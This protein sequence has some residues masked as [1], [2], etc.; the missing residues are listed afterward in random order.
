MSRDATGELSFDYQ[1]SEGASEIH[2]TSSGQLAAA[3]WYNVCF[4]R[5]GNDCGLYYGEA[6]SAL[7]QVAFDNVWTV[8]P[9]GFDAA[10]EIGR[11]ST[12]YIDARMEDIVIARQNLFDAAPVSGLTDTITV[13]AGPIN[14][15]TGGF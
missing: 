10:V 15:V 12:N 4:V 8:D 14:F 1:R 13:P 6:G 9:A 2:M 5:K 3:T 7:S 11:W